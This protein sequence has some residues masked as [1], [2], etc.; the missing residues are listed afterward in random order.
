MFKG[1]SNVFKVYHKKILISLV[2]LFTVLV[3]EKVLFLLINLLSLAL[4]NNH[5]GQ[6]HNWESGHVGTTVTPYFLVRSCFQ[7]DS[8][9]NTEISSVSAGENVPYAIFYSHTLDNTSLI[10]HLSITILKE[11]I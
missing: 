5:W 6:A 11:N 3:Y 10:I 2:R 7:F 9:A 8:L 4:A 1:F